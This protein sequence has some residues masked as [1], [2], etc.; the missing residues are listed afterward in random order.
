MHREKNET[1][2]KATTQHSLDFVRST[3]GALV[4]HVSPLIT[5]KI[6][7]LLMLSGNQ[8]ILSVSLSHAFTSIP[9]RRKHTHSQCHAYT[10]HMHI[11]RVQF[12]HPILGFFFVFLTFCFTSLFSRQR[13]KQCAP[14][15][16]RERKESESCETYT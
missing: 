14:F 9:R 10:N 4:V 12:S 8:L 13:H 2:V 6:E 15:S 1:V 11:H 3:H 7:N 5:L 16:E